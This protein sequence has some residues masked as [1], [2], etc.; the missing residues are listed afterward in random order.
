VWDLLQRI[1]A[2]VK[3]FGVEL[4]CEIHEDFNHNMQLA[5]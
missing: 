1:R 4:L 3:P 5:K 2:V